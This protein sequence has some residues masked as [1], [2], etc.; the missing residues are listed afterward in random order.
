MWSC[1]DQPYV[2]REYAADGVTEVRQTYTGYNLSQAYLD[3]HIIGSV[4]AV[5]I[6]NGSEW[7]TKIGY[8]YDAG[9]D[10]LQA[11][12]AAA[13]QHDAAYGTDFTAR[14]NVTAVARY[15]VTD[16]NNNNKRLIT[17][18]GYDVDGS[19]V[20]SRDPMNRQSTMN[21]TDTVYSTT[22]NNYNARDQITSTVEQRASGASQTVG[23]ATRKTILATASTAPTL[24]T[25]WGESSKP[26]QARRPEER[27]IAIFVPTTSPM[28]M[29]R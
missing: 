20:F 11:T 26:H 13:T 28:N 27:R 17:Q 10:Q 24:T 19:V 12:Q 21:Y 5:H 23:C 7:Q 15:D 8:F 18:V 25:M 16:I 22:V 14:G 6:S 9:G 3:Q 4:S 29:T 2:V 1:V